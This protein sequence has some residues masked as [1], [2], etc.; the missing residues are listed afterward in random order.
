VYAV[1]VVIHL[2]ISA[3]LVIVILLQSGRGGGLAGA[4]GGGG[5]SQTIFGGRGAATFLSKSTSILGALFMVSAM[6][7]AM[8]STRAPAK[9]Q[10]SVIE[11]IIRKEQ[12]AQPSTTTGQQQGRMPAARTPMEQPMP[13]QTPATTPAQG[14]QQGAQV[15]QKTAPGAGVVPSQTTPTKSSGQTQ[16]QAKP[17]AAQQ[18]P[19]QTGA[20]TTGGK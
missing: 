5:G 7:L 16:E 18:N 3:A 9:T 4:F 20:K 19:S 2:L 11:D 1:L 8:V 13:S 10:R 12:P 15:G 14:S 17:P 6:T